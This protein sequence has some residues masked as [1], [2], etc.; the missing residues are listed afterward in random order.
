[1]CQLGKISDFSGNFANICRITL[2]LGNYQSLIFK[3]FVLKIVYNYNILCILAAAPLE[4][5]GYIFGG[6]WDSLKPYSDLFI[7]NKIA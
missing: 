5:R 4:S 3:C 7:K 6:I 1:M 2:S